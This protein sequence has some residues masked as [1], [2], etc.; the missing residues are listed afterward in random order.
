M[1]HINSKVCD[2]FNQLEEVGS[3]NKNIIKKKKDNETAK[4][5]C[6][7]AIKALN[8]NLMPGWEVDIWSKERG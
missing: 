6:A 2:F 3:S 8:A 7:I 5:T 4:M 1:E